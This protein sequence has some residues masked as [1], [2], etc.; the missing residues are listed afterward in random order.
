MVAHTCRIYIQS[1]F[2][3]CTRVRESVGGHEFIERRRVWERVSSGD[4]RDFLFPQIFLSLSRK[5]ERNL[6]GADGG[7]RII[8]L[9][10]MLFDTR[11]YARRREKRRENDETMVVTG[12]GWEFAYGKRSYVCVTTYSVGFACAVE[13]SAK[14]LLG[15]LSCWSDNRTNA[16][17]ASEMITAWLRAILL[18]R[19]FTRNIR[20]IT[21]AFV[22]L[23]QG[24]RALLVSERAA[25]VILSTTSRRSLKRAFI[26]RDIIDNERRDDVFIMQ[27][28]AERKQYVC[29]CVHARLFHRILQVTWNFSPWTSLYG[30]L[31]TRVAHIRKNS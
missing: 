30:T 27:R 4:A 20:G 31:V 5:R 6:C 15:S 14:T 21:C 12:N 7:R 23:A 28:E 26:S 2:L 8:S 18:W 24:N 25:V 13:I 1:T 11:V 10:A 19:Q 17:V 16:R 9:S 29:V 3:A 22:H